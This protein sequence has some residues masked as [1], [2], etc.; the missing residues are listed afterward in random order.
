PDPEQEHFRMTEGESRDFTFL[1]GER[2]T[3]QRLTSFLALSYPL[4]AI[5]DPGFS[6]TQI[7]N[8]STSG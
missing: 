6:K 4:P 5:P 1:L 7:L 8:R 2:I 3:I